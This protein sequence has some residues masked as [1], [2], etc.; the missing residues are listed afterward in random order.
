M[1]S[2]IRIDDEEEVSFAGLVLRAHKLAS[3]SPPSAF[4][5]AVRNLL[6]AERSNVRV[7][8]SSLF[9]S[10]GYRNTIFTVGMQ[11]VILLVE[12]G[13][14]F[15]LAFYISKV[16]PGEHGL[17]SRW[18][19]PVKPYVDKSSTESPATT[20]LTE[21]ENESCDGQ[22]EFLD[23]C[24]TVLLKEVTKKY[25]IRGARKYAV[26]DVT[27]K[28]RKNEIT[29]LLG[30]NGAG[31]STIMKM[32]SGHISPSS[33]IIMVEGKMIGGSTRVQIGVCPQ[34]NVLFPSLTVFEHLRFYAIL[35][36][37]NLSQKEVED[38]SEEMIADL[39]LEHKRDARAS[40]LSGGMQRRLC[41]GIAFIAGSKTV[42]LD[43]PTAGVDPFARR[44]IWDL[45]LKYKEGHTI[46]I[47]TH[48]MDEAD[49]LGDRIAIL[50][51]GTLRAMDTP[52]GLKQ[53][54]GNGYRLKIAMK[55][56]GDSLEDFLSWLKC[57]GGEV[58]LLDSYNKQVELGLPEWKISQVAAMLTDIE[59]RCDAVEFP[60]QTY[61]I[62][63]STLEE[64]FVKLI[65][66][67]S[68][69][70]MVQTFEDRE[71]T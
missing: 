66:K 43:E 61:S 49:I 9:M 45:I 37:R 7:D 64:V 67:Q 3:L 68:S 56:K 62:N 6:F 51:E 12:S 71:I 17:A 35:K 15:V 63:D 53:E 42:I 13:V 1:T 11:M 34:H 50:S 19:F 18:F 58:L 31:K 38:A 33:G 30:E 36:N 52:L 70:G 20:M 41:I 27:I 54:Y 21:T 25:N 16:F 57:Y 46:I 4:E 59:R 29:A 39:R 26:R 5:I 47:A 60:V 44:A 14:F 55:S 22:R 24:C 32:I 28:F 23:K 48:F 10:I 2:S 40:T 65:G 69:R 8:W